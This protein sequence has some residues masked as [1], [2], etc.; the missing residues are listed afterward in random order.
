MEKEKL[1]KKLK[2]KGPMREKSD[3][4]IVQE[5]L[6]I[7]ASSNSVYCIELIFDLLSAGGI[8][9]GDP[10]KYRVNTPGT[11]SHGNWS[12]KIP[13]RLEALLKDKVNS[14]IKEI[15]AAGKR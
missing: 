11:V 4:D 7:T 10:Y 13:I 14:T 2:L 15:I 1:W 3:Q 6:K 9:K 12:L 5:A 8:C